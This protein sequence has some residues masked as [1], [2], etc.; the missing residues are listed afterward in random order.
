MFCR[1]SHEHGRLSTPFH[2]WIISRK[3]FLR[4]TECASFDRK[5][6]EARSSVINVS[7]ITQAWRDEGNLRFSVPLQASFGVQT[8]TS[9]NFLANTRWPNYKWPWSRQRKHRN[10][11]FQ[12]EAYFMHNGTRKSGKD[13]VNNAFVSPAD[14]CDFNSHI[15]SQTKS[16]CHKN[17]F[18]LL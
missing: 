5:A 15:F 7:E 4:G 14:C 8:G 12:R 11:V 2:R 18:V 3:D 1:K 13:S 10:D 6:I 9:W 16:L 17:S